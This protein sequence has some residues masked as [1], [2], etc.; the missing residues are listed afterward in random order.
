M[1][2]HFNIVFVFLCHFGCGCYFGLR[3]QLRFFFAAL[4]AVACLRACVVIVFF[5]SFLFSCFFSD[6][7]SSGIWSSFAELSGLTLNELCTS[8]KS[9][10]LASKANGTTDA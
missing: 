9:A 7:F 6:V 4:S 2:V 5:R 1:V 8:L 10:V 3:C